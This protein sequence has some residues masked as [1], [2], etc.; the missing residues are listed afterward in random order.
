MELSSWFH[1]I[2][3]EPYQEGPGLIL[4]GAGVG[5]FTGLG[6]VL[7]HYL[8]AGIHSAALCGTHSIAQN[9]LEYMPTSPWDAWIILVPVIGALLMTVLVRNFAP[10]SPQYS[11]LPW[12]DGFLAME[13][14]VRDWRP[15]TVL[16]TLVATAS[17]SGVTQEVF[18]SAHLFAHASISYWNGSLM[19]PTFAVVGGLMALMSIGFVRL[20]DS[21]DTYSQQL[22]LNSHARHMSGMLLT[23]ILLYFTYRLTDHYCLIGGSYTGMSGVLL[24]QIHW[25][26][27]LLAIKAIANNLIRATGGRLRGGFSRLPCLWGRRWVAV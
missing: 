12:E 20:M 23:D 4:L 21:V 13:V 10:E 1:L 25:P 24:N 11:M 5:L 26:L 15:W 6:V 7:F 16:F 14:I 27:L 8:I 3:L 18:G 22:L 19:L 9:P 2:S 17:A